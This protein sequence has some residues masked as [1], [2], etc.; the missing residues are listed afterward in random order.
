MKKSQYGIQHYHMQRDIPARV[1]LLR[2]LR[3]DPITWFGHVI[4]GGGKWMWQAVGV[5]C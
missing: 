1:S 4:N 3:R 5:V 2:G